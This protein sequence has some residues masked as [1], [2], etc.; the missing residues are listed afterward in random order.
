MIR[1]ADPVAEERAKYDAMWSHQDYAAW[2]PGLDNV[3]RFMSVI[4]PPRGRSLVDFGCGDG[5]A[6]LEF[7]KRGLRPF[8]ID[9]TDA[10]LVAEV[11]RARFRAQPLWERID[12]P[13]KGAR[14]DYGFCCDV[15]E[16]IPTE[17]VMLTLQR[18]LDACELLWLQI[19]LV[20]D[21][22]G[23]V[24]GTPLHLTVRPFRWW[25]ERIASVARVEDARDLLECGLY[26]ARGRR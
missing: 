24:I 18:M 6:G 25:L 15:M 22:Y 11:P 20:E 3:A 5:R 19:A 1:A 9:L 17:Y 12:P 2:S 13:S 26:V 4:D 7:Q 21:A 14:F 10:G 23:H 16:H 8:W